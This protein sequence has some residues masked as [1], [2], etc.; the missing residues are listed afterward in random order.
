MDS[1]LRGNDGFHSVSLHPQPKNMPNRC[2]LAE[3]RQE[4]KALIGGL[5]VLYP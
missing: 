5:G 3:K 1:R 2:D 4:D